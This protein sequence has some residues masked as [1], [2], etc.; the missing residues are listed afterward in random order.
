M[1]KGSAKAVPAGKRTAAEKLQYVKETYFD[2]TM[3][4]DTIIQERVYYNK[5][6]RKQQYR[7]LAF[8]FI[9]PLLL[10]YNLYYCQLQLMNTQGTHKKHTGIAGK[11][12]P[13]EQDRTKTGGKQGSLRDRCA[14]GAKSRRTVHHTLR[15]PGFRLTGFILTWNLGINHRYFPCPNPLLFLCWHRSRTHTRLCR[16]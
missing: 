3:D 2:S 12:I 15:R 9:P 11:M 5:T 6:S 16:G 14:A 13:G 7:R 4:L 8:M 10:H 1:K